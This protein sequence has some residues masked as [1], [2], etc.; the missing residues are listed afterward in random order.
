MPTAYKRG[1]ILERERADF[2]VMVLLVRGPADRQSLKLLVVEP[3]FCPLGWYDA[4]CVAAGGWRQVNRG[5]A[6]TEGAAVASARSA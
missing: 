2:R 3:S 5:A 4:A 6:V 1:Q